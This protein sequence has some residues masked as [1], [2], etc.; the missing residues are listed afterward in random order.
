MLTA[1]ESVRETGI[2]ETGTASGTEIATGET[3]VTLISLS[4]FKILKMPTDAFPVRSRRPGGDHWEPE[5]R[6]NGEVS[7]MAV[8]PSSHL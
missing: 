3:P 2:G 1:T 4:L 6:R 7:T 5:E 8:F